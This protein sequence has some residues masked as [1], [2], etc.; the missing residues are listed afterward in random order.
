MSRS[1]GVA[2]PENVQKKAIRNAKLLKEKTNATKALKK[3]TKEARRTQCMLRAGGCGFLILTAR[4][5][6]A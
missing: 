2:V 1:R 6:T 3:A 5:A 4:R